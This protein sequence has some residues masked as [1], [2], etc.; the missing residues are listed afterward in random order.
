LYQNFPEENISHI[1]HAAR[2]I[3]KQNY[4]KQLQGKKRERERER[5][6]AHPLSKFA[7]DFQKHE[8]EPTCQRLINA[9]KVL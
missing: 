6:R 4:Q 1:I 5:E 3:T 8:K 7:I 9:T 2:C